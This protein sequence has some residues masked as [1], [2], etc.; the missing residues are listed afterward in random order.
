DD[1]QGP[2]EIRNGHHRRLPVVLELQGHRL[3]QCPQPDDHPLEV[4]LALPGDA[5][6]IALDLRLDLRELLADQL[7][8]L[9]RENVVEAPAQADRLADLVAACGLDLAP[10]E[11]LQRQVATD[12]LRLDQVL[13]R[14]SPVLVVRQEHELLLGLAELDGHALEIEPLADLAPDLVE[15]VAQLLLVEVADDVERNLSGHVPPVRVCGGR[16]RAAGRRMASQYALD[17]ARKSLSAW[18]A[19]PQAAWRSGSC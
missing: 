1:H 18:R 13:D 3:V 14:G 12:R 15:G 10:L 5:D 19:P 6:R 16:R 2:L 4:V 11:D 9:L 17:G 8:D 7:R